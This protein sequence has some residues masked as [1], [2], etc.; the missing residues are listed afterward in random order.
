MITTQQIRDRIGDGFWP[1]DPPEAI[2]SPEDWAAIQARF[3]C[4]F[5]PEFH[6]LQELMSQFSFEGDYLRIAQH[7]RD[8][9]I[10]SV[11]EAEAKTGRLWQKDLIPFYDVGNGDFVCLRASEC[12]NSPV[13]YIYHEDDVVEK[14]HD[15]LEQWLQDPEWFP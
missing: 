15:S 11:C 14:V 3:G 10:G 1:K 13:Y 9:D 4:A 12:P 8:S 7:P 5:P 2:P 6:S